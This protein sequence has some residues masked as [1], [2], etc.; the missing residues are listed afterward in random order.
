MLDG[1]ARK[2]IEPSLN[3][4]GRALA[5]AGVS[6]NTVTLFA[7]AL[8]MAA[9]LAIALGHFW[10]GL[11][12]LLISRLGDGLDGAVAKATQRTDLG[13]YL[14]IV[15]DFAF[16]GAIPLGFVIANPAA[17]AVAGAVLVL[18]F[19]V[20]GASFLA[21]AIMAEKRNLTTQARG[22]KSLFFTTGLAEASE[23]IA[24]FVLFCLFPA[25]FGPIA[26]IFA[27]IC[28]YTALSRVVL[29]ARTLS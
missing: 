20:N 6:A 3:R 14:D 27:G 15:L 4:I 10:L 22:E 21:Y 24:T 1:W 12:L 26:Y 9:A 23:T 29:A 17:N 2:R 8:G 18:S 7:F 16:Y 5:D 11:A 28:F 25:Y 13:G 19:Y